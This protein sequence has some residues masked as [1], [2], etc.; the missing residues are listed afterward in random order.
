MDRASQKRCIEGLDPPLKDELLLEFNEDRFD[1][2]LDSEPIEPSIP[3][4]RNSKFKNGQ[5]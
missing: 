3:K 1:E 4:L 2:G 5:T